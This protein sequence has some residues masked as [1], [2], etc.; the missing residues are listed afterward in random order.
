MVRQGRRYRWRLLGA[1][2]LFGLAIGALYGSRWLAAEPGSPEDVFRRIHIGMSKAEALSALRASDHYHIDGIY[3]E[4][5]T[6]AGHS[7]SGT[8]LEGPLFEDLPPAQ[9]IAHCVLSI[10]DSEGREVEV[11]LGPG[12]VVSSKRLSPGVWQYRLDKVRMALARAGS[13]LGSGLWWAEQLRKASRSLHRRPRYAVVCL[14]ALLLT[15]AWFLRRKA[16]RCGLSRARSD[17]PIKAEVC[18]A[19]DPARE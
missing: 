12:G 14:A 16:A 5:I 18:A 1:G 4:G 13:D 3:S 15:S 8:K 10:L 17:K 6:Q 9:D 2:L 19:A 7:W 11:V